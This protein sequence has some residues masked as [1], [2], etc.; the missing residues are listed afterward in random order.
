[1]NREFFAETMITTGIAI[2]G[3]LVV[4]LWMTRDPKKLIEETQK[5]TLAIV[6]LSMQMKF[7]TEKLAPIPKLQE[8]VNKLHGWR[9][10]LNESNDTRE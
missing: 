2:I 7:L 10:S 1:M 4:Q 3:F 6:E 5:N 9:K 8:D